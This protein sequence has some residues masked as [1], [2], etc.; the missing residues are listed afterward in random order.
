MIANLAI[1]QV[2]FH[3]S[4]IFTFLLPHFL[5]LLLFLPL[6]FFVFVS[7]AF[8][9]FPTGQPTA[10]PSSQPSR[11]PTSVPTL[12]PSLGV[13]KNPTGQPTSAPSRPIILPVVAGAATVG[14]LSIP[15]VMIIFSAVGAIFLCIFVCFSCYFQ[16]KFLNKE[17]DR[18]L[19]LVEENLDDNDIILDDGEGG[20]TVRTLV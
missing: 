4:C 2:I 1:T 16:H 20:D 15:S 9:V 12:T 7:T 5:L 13:S 11:Q 14:G 6:F 18:I 8:T 19:F 17:E 10:L 3:N